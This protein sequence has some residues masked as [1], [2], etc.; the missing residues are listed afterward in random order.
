[1]FLETGLVMVFSL[2]SDRDCLI[3]SAGKSILARKWILVWVAV[4]VCWHAESTVAQ[5]FDVV[6]D[7]SG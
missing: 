7:A 4:H 6:P 2:S 3:A 5:V 1:M